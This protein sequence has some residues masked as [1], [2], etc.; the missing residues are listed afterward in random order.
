MFLVHLMLNGLVFKFLVFFL[1]FFVTRMEFLTLTV[2]SS[3]MC[4]CAL[5]IGICFCKGWN[6]S[7]YSEFSIDCDEK[8]VCYMFRNVII[9]EV[10]ITNYKNHNHSN[11]T[12]SE[13]SRTYQEINIHIHAHSCKK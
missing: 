8:N 6:R 11:S 1:F 5:Y 10:S 4:V 3:N 9:F 2:T 13:R 7:R 12:R